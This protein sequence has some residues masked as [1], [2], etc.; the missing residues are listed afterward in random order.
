MARGESGRAEIG[1]RRKSCCGRIA[2]S[3]RSSGVLTAAR[4]PASS[5][6]RHNVRLP[7]VRNGR[8]PSSF[9]DRTASTGSRSTKRVF[10]H[11]NGF[12]SVEENTTLDISVSCAKLG[13]SDVAAKSDI[14]RYV[15]AP[16]KAV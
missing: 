2:H 13:S 6:D 1:S 7:I 11:A 5:N 3:C 12:F 14:N 15:V 4:R 16:I 10:A 9:I 8:A